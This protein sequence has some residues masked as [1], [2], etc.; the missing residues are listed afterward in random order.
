MI[1]LQIIGREKVV[2][3]INVTTNIINENTKKVRIL[4]WTLV[5]QQTL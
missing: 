4:M 3:Y 2:E 5:E 1:Y